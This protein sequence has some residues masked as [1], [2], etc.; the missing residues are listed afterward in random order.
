[1][2]G[3]MTLEELMADGSRIPVAPGVGM[4]LS[5]L[6]AEATSSVEQ[7]AAV[8]KCDPSLTAKVLKMANSAYF[9]SQ[10][11]IGNLAE[12][13]VRLG[14]R[15]VQIMALAFCIVNASHGKAKKYGFSYPYFWSHAL[16]TGTFADELAA[17]RRLRLSAEAM[18]AGLLQD[19]G[20]LVIQTAMPEDY[21]KV[22]AY[23]K[24]A[25]G[26]LY[27][28]E[29]RHLG[30]DH[31]QAGAMLLRRW[32]LP[33]AVCQV[34]GSHHQPDGSGETVE[35]VRDLAQVCEVGAAVGKVLT[36][37]QGRL[38]LAARAAELAERHFGMSAKEFQDLLQ[39]V[40]MKLDASSEMFELKLDETVVSRLD[41]TIRNEVAENVLH[42]TEK[43]S[44]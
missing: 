43:S 30:F 34:V 29:T 4:E 6:C 37:D 33:E 22:L 38:A 18:A 24:K 3:K 31:A 1:M 16:V 25:G 9:A 15:R 35:G 23:Y 26:E 36:H 32:H 44:G 5:R 14:L 28:A 2:A 27:V 11:E 7:L 40:R 8:L 39:V 20:V 41:A 21:A 19:I 42:M 13:I 17:R 10:R 12:A